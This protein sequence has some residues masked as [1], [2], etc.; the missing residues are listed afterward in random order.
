MKIPLGYNNGYR[1]KIFF[2][3]I[4]IWNSPCQKQWPI[5]I[6]HRECIQG[7][8]SLSNRIYSI[9]N[10]QPGFKPW[11]TWLD[12]VKDVVNIFANSLFCLFLLVTF[13]I[14]RASI[15][16]MV[17]LNL[18]PALFFF[19]ENVIL[20][21]FEKRGIML[22][23]KAWKFWIYKILTKFVFC[24][25]ENKWKL[26]SITRD[27]ILLHLIYLLSQQQNLMVTL[28]W[29]TCWHECEMGNDWN[30]KLTY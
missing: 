5:F 8:Y 1:P 30:K 16:I 19:L 18:W 9:C 17:A 23:F 3:M 25:L 20:F 11:I 4:L 24:T 28:K 26:E 10:G 13:L 29:V 12:Y 2:N 6:E 7:G 21:F 15:I 14:F 27:I 22:E